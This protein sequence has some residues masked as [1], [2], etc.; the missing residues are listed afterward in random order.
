[1]RWARICVRYSDVRV[2]ANIKLV[3]DDLVFIVL[4]LVESNAWVEKIDRKLL[5][6]ADETGNMNKQC[7]YGSRRCRRFPMENFH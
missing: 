7:N 1:M 6:I 3:V 2:P 5:E 4:V